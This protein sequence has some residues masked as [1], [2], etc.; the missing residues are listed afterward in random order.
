M[1][2]DARSALAPL[3]LLA[4]LVTACP[5]SDEPD[6]HDPQEAIDMAVAFEQNLVRLDNGPFMTT[7]LEG[8]GLARAWADPAAAELFR[9]LAPGQLDMS[10]P[11]PEGTI[12]VKENF[13][14]EGNPVDVLNVMMKFEPGYHEEGGDWFFAAITREGEVIENLVGQPIAGNGVAVEFCRDCHDQMGGTSDYVIGLL[15]EQ[16]AP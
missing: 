8:V 13:D 2:H 7:H 14:A 15:P 12:F 11:F 4:A 10:E 6:G 5:S 1:R 9:S 16:Q 3:A